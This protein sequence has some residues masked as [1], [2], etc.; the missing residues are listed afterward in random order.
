M[1]MLWFGMGHMVN[2]LQMQIILFLAKG[3]SNNNIKFDVEITPNLVFWCQTLFVV[4]NHDTK[5]YTKIN[6]IYYLLFSVLI[7]FIF[8]LFETDKNCVSH[9][10]IMSIKIL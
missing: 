5:D 10:D 2:S 6:N 3:I 8:L 9:L 4:S 1:E 7:T